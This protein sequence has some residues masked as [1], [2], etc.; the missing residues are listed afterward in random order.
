[1][2]DSHLGD[3]GVRVSDRLDNTRFLFFGGSMLVPGVVRH[4]R[5]WA[6]KGLAWRRHL[7]VGLVCWRWNKGAPERWGSLLLQLSSEACEL[8][9]LNL[10]LLLL[11]LE[12]LLLQGE[13]L[14]LDP[15]GTRSILDVERV[16]TGC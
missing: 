14:L 10:E 4:G 5:G 2:Q 9:F 1:M 6:A 3:R 11:D 16:G 13:L 15:E 12:P 7:G 8:G